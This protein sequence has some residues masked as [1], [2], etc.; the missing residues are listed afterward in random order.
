MNSLPSELLDSIALTIPSSEALKL[1]LS[2]FPQALFTPVLSAL[3]ELVYSNVD[4]QWPMVTVSNPT[5]WPLKCIEQLVFFQPKISL[6]YPITS[7][8]DFVH[9]H[10]MNK[11]ITNITVAPAGNAKLTLSIGS[12]LCSEL[13][14]CS[15]ESVQI[16]VS[17]TRQFTEWLYPLFGLLDIPSLQEYSLVYPVQ[18][19]RAISSVAPREFGRKLLNWL[20]AGKS[21][22]LELCNVSWYTDSQLVCALIDA[23]QKCTSLETLCLENV[24]FFE[25]HVFYGSNLPASVHTFRWYR[26]RSSGLPWA[27]TTQCLALA[28]VHATQLKSLDL[29]GNEGLD[30]DI[31]AQVIPTLLQ[32]KSLNL[33]GVQLSQTLIEA[34]ARLPHLQS[35]DLG[36]RDFNG[37]S[38]TLARV[39]PSCV[40]LQHLSLVN[41][42]P[43][44]ND[45]LHT[46]VSVLP[47]I[48]SLQ[49]IAWT[50]KVLRR[51]GILLLESILP[52]CPKLRS[53]TLTGELCSAH[54][55][56]A[57]VFNSFSSLRL[58]DLVLNKYELD[59]KGACE[60]AKVLPQCAHLRS[61]DISNNLYTGK[62]LSAIVESLPSTVQAVNLASQGYYLDGLKAT[63]V[64]LSKKSWKTLDVSV[65]Y[66]PNLVSFLELLSTTTTKKLDVKI[67]WNILSPGCY[68]EC[69]NVIQKLNSRV[70]PIEC[71][72]IIHFNAKTK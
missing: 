58:E 62:G 24:S 66:E 34:F 37:L 2:A 15:L 39:L 26:R 11:F 54:A 6:A 28:L 55:Y 57:P 51:P 65:N 43:T 70:G 18:V 32:L 25:D 49:S 23:L 22:K 64:A 12:K 5:A 67:P 69:A 47:R 4:V 10:S 38:T 53:L 56:G 17:Q 16:D 35:L 42:V 3:H 60:L 40:K 68:H 46:L 13:K 45:D 44:A 8:K 30:P 41:R 50:S 61:I 27:T 63:A 48:P 71:K 20:L 1:F 21:T 36:G 31:L 19:H 7:A 29:S 9:A 52:Q 14:T 59:D 33:N 72:I